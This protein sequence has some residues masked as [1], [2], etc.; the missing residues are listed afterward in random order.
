MTEAK[1]SKLPTIALFCTAGITAILISAIAIAASI[2]N[3]T[4]NDIF[5]QLGAVL[6]LL[7][8]VTAIALI[9]GIL[10]LCALRGKLKVIDG[11]VEIAYT[12]RLKTLYLKLEYAQIEQIYYIQT[13]FEKAVKEGTVFIRT[14][15]RKTYPIRHVKKAASAVEALTALKETGYEK[16]D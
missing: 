13:L 8:L 7:M 12:K 16:Q 3:Y 2:Y 6:V 11:G 5:N 1:I 4:V 10:S 9:K 15:D 14:T